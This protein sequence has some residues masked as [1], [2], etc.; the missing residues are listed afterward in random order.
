M[1]YP[2]FSLDLFLPYSLPYLTVLRIARVKY[3]GEKS[4]RNESS[5]NVSPFYSRLFR[6][7]TRPHEM[8]PFIVTFGFMSCDRKIS[9]IYRRKGNREGRDHEKDTD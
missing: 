5:S 6:F 3:N 2:L 7:A 4:T 1:T 8:D 9:E